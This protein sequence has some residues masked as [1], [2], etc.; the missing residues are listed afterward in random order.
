MPERF[1][2]IARAPGW[3]SSAAARS[4]SGR[5]RPMAPVAVGASA[6]FASAAAALDARHRSRGSHHCR[7]K[8]HVFASRHPIIPLSSTSAAIFAV[9][10]AAYTAGVGLGGGSA[11][12]VRRHGG[13]LIP[14]A[15][16][17]D[18]GRSRPGIK[19]LAFN[20]PRLFC[21]IAIAEQGR[22]TL[23][24][25][26][27]EA[28]VTMTRY[29]TPELKDLPEDMQPASWRCRRRPASCPTC[30]S[31]WRAAWPSGAPSSPTTTR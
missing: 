22:A 2:P 6:S 11:I 1:T 29:P 21:R 26:S 17:A 16:S 8:T 25:T 5:G 23:G 13:R 19:K 30:S 20:A 27:G 14:T 31:R 4:D 3:S 28:F 9:S 7:L 10:N 15:L 24:Q 18:T 12:D